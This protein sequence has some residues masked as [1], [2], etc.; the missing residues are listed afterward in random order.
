MDVTVK[1]EAGKAAGC[2]HRVV[3]LTTGDGKKHVRVF[4]DN[5]ILPENEPDENELW[6]ASMYLIRQEA[7]RVKDPITVDEAKP[8]IEA[9][10]YKV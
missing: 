5:E 10:G 6:K 1:I 4:A 3:T 9:G 7:K 8:A 2:K